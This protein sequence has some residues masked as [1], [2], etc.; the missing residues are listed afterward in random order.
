M[1]L[2][3]GIVAA[4]IIFV[5]NTGHPSG[6]PIDESSQAQVYRPPKTVTA[7]AAERAAALSTLSRFVRS[8]VIRRDLASSWSLATAHMKYGTSHSDWLH[9]NL[10]VVPYPADAYRTAGFT[11]KYQYQDILGYDVLVLPSE[12]KAGRLAGQQ[13]YACELHDVG[14]SWLVDACYPRKTL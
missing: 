7:S 12:T 5:P 9:G 1:G 14:G 11:L 2:A 4:L 8:A 6:T 13:V 3:L 10:P